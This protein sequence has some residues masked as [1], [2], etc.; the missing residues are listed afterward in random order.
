MFPLGLVT[1]VIVA[2]V[3]VTAKSAV[4]TLLMASEKVISQTNSSAL[5]GL[6][7][8]DCLA[9]LLTVGAVRSFRLTVLLDV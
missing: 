7:E 1:E 6:E 4:P 3:P 5:V 2:V 9:I 8:G